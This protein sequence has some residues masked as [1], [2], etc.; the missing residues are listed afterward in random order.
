M[1][2]G[3]FEIGLVQVRSPGWLGDDVGGD[4][5][6]DD[7]RDGQDPGD[8]LGEGMQLRA[9][10]GVEISVEKG[11]AKAKLSQNR[12]S[13]DREGVVRGLAGEGSP[14]AAAVAEAM[15]LDNR[16]DAD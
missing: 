3:S 14:G 11:D 13:A 7:G 16:R 12:S 8:A 10:V 1:G 4:G 2:T 15:A 6:G 5:A 9:I